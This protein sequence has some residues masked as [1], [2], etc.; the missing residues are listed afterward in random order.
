MDFKKDLNTDIF[1][2]LINKKTKK[3]ADNLQM[4]YL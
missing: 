1:A 4:N 3:T 2:F